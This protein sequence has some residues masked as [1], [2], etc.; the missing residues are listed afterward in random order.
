LPSVAITFESDGNPCRDRLWPPKADYQ[1]G[2]FWRLRLCIYAAPLRA[3]SP[4]YPGSGVIAPGRSN[5]QRLDSHGQVSPRGLAGRLGL[6]VGGL[7]AVEPGPSPGQLA[8]LCGAFAAVCR[9]GPDW[10]RC[11]RTWLVR[12]VLDNRDTANRSRCSAS[13]IWTLTRDSWLD[14]CPVVRRVMVEPP[15]VH[16]GPLGHRDSW[17]TP[18]PAVGNRPPARVVPPGPM[19]LG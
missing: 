6:T 11:P 18:S 13:S 4:A 3:V 10:L 2:R 19:M 16:S 12:M 5:G 9:V 15:A 14:S 7:V 8:R 1:R 17:K